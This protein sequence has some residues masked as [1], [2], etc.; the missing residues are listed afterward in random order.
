MAS[1]RAEFLTARDRTHGK[2]AMASLHVEFIVARLRTTTWEDFDAAMAEYAV[3]Q[4]AAKAAEKERK[5]EKAINKRESHH[6]KNVE[7]ARRAEESSAEIQAR[8]AAAD[9]AGKEND[10]VWPACPCE[11]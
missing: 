6:R 2:Y 4:E 9:K 3:E 1:C 5:M 11:K 7:A 10:G 8:W